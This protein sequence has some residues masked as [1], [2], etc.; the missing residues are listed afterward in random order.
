[1]CRRVDAAELKQFPRTLTRHCERSEAIQNGVQCVAAVLDCFVASLLAMTMLIQSAESALI[2]DQPRLS[3]IAPQHALDGLDR[4]RDARRDLAIDGFE[5]PRARGGLIEIGGEAGAVGTKR[6]DLVGQHG[7]VAIG[8]KSPPG[9]GFERV[10][11]KRQAPA[12]NVDG[13]GLAHAPIRLPHCA[14]KLCAGNCL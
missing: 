2:G 10:E 8:L 9:R 5:R 7:L 3:L 6:M 4:L 13:I 1:M 14:R 11:G 12:R